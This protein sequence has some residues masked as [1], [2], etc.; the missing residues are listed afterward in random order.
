MKLGI[1]ASLQELSAVSAAEF[2]YVELPLCAVVALSDAD[3]SSLRGQLAKKGLSC[4]AM[5]L[6]LAPGLRLLGEAE[7]LRALQTYARS[8]FARA[9]T[10]GARLLVLG[11][12]GARR[13][14]EGMPREQAEQRL[15][16]ACALL[17]QEAGRQDVMIVLEPLNRAETDLIHTVEQGRLLT[18]KVNSPSFRLLADFYHMQR[19][20]EPV[21]DLYAAAPLLRHCHIALG[22]DRHFPAEADR[23]AV[24]TFLSALRKIDYPG[25]LSVE[26]IPVQFARDAH[27]SAQLLRALAAEVC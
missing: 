21:S 7:D 20:N 12:G 15:L 8:A 9:R 24:C 10:L 5:N 16:E 26:G 2:D 17:A 23:D 11:S 1:C 25:A 6:M 13:I 27:M 4:D 19:E 22:A 14:P 3:V 18:E